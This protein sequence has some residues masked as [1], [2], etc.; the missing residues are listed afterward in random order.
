MI[1]NAHIDP[2]WLWGWQE[3][4]ETIRATFKS[5]I[6]RLEEYPEF[7][8]TASSAFFYKWLEEVDGELFAKI[9][10]K[11]KEGR[12]HLV[13]GWWVEPDCNIPGGEALVRQGLYGQRYFYE[14][15]G[16]RAKVG[17]N[18]DSFG[19][20][21]M[22]PPIL[23]KMGIDYY[24]FM[25]PDPN[26]K[27]LS[28]DIF[29]W[30]GPD[31]SRVLA[32]RIP[33]SYSGPPG[34]LKEHIQKVSEAFKP[35]ELKSLE[36]IMCFYGRGDHG[37]GPTGENIESIKALS[38]QS[39]NDSPR[40]LFSS[41]DNYFEE[42]SSKNLSLPVVKDE[43][44][45]HASGCYSALSW[46]KK[47]NR[48]LE[49][50]L[51][52]AEKFSLM[53]N[54][55]NKNRVY[56]QVKLTRAWQMLL[57]TQFHDILGGVSIPEVYDEVRAV[58]GEVENV[59]SQVI[60]GAIQSIAGK[61]NTDGEGKALLIFNS[62]SFERKIPLEV[63]YQWQ[64][65]EIAVIDKDGV[66]VL[67]QTLRI[68]STIPPGWRK[69]ICFIAE[70][71]AFGY[72]TYRLIPKSIDVPQQSRMLSVTS[73]LL[74]N[75]WLQVEIDSETGYIERIYDKKNH[76]EILKGP[77]AI[78]V[79]IKDLSDTWSHN[80]FRFKNEAGRFSNATVKVL[81]EG[82]V[83]GKVRIKSNFH[84]STLIQEVT[85]YRDLDIIEVKVVIDWHERQ[86][87]LKFSFP[88]NVASPKAIYQIPYGFI[89]RP[90]SGEEEPGLSWID[91]SD[92]DYGLS[93][94]NDAKYSYDV[95]GSDLRLTV[96]RSPVYAH[97]IPKVL[98]P[99]VD[100]Q[101]IDQGEQ[102]FTYILIPHKGG[103]QKALPVRWAENLNNPP[104]VLVEH[105]HK[106]R[107]P[108]EQ[109]FIKVDKENVMVTVFKKA[110]DTEDTVLRLYETKGESSETNIALFERSWKVQ[111]NPCE[112]KTFLIPRDK[113]APVKEVNL[114]EF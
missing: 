58:H 96:L 106:G 50:L 40:T 105:C 36:R 61:V 2:V 73:H 94:V 82:S 30:E 24:V 14:K 18:P 35:D 42:V 16:V 22:L 85:L 87:M 103:C 15:F 41:P 101:Y 43:L 29:W 55:L 37:G 53:A 93:L 34:D 23:K 59:S 66:P 21:I 80:V 6:E 89:Q 110:E 38:Q 5:V 104:V 56:P 39:L 60:N 19:H 4:S 86:R 51:L 72:T 83:R 54:Y 1:G 68:S 90:C 67:S 7:V 45:H 79:V 12:W 111:L 44:Q 57:F 99:D 65:D 9:R 92:D 70:V 74:E 71:P 63:E 76:K 109:S 88:I 49:N 3:G 32:Y 26:E 114:L 48:K 81:E 13:G 62:T 20:N 69:R 64:S 28:S 78:P 102:T 10:Q 8:F 75:D 97:H 95:E 31:G 98:E 46:I 100:Y 11:V 107:L 77:G 17:F 84:N 112:I 91:V 52:T 47:S 108:K 113:K 25:R 27:K 33:F